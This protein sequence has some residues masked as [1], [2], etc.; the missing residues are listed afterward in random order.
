MYQLLLRACVPI[1]IK[2]NSKKS[3]HHAGENMSNYGSRR[4][5]LYD[6]AYNKKR[7]LDPDG[8][9]MWPVLPLKNIRKND[10]EMP[11]FVLTGW[12]HATDIKAG[13]Y[14]VTVG[15]LFIP[16]TKEQREALPQLTYPTIDALLI[17]GWIGD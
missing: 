3:R 13:Q 16:Y 6:E 7:M 4:S 9:P 15:C 11:S 1:P 12:M 10:P 2:A 17:D 14:I 8:W 5:K